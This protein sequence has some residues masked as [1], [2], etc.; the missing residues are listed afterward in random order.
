MCIDGAGV[1]TAVRRFHAKH[2]SAHATASAPSPVRYRIE[3]AP[4]STESFSDLALDVRPLE[5][6]G[7]ETL[8]RSPAALIHGLGLRRTAEYLP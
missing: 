2:A 5:P 1:T 8:D 7:A 3:L 6:S 4:D